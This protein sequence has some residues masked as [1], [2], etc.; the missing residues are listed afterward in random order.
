MSQKFANA[1]R[2]RLVSGINA[3]VTTITVEAPTADLFPIVNTTDWL[4]KNDWFKA[5]LQNSLGQ[6]EIIHVGVRA[7]GSGVF[8]NVLRGQDGTTARE[9]NAGDVVG[10]RL[11]AL[12]HEGLINIKSTDNTFTG[13]NTFEQPIVGNLNGNAETATLAAVATLANA[14]VDEAVSTTKIVDEAVTTPKIDDQAVT[15]PKLGDEAVTQEKLAT[16]VTDR[17]AQ[18]GDLKYTARRTAPPGWLKAN[19]A[20]VSRTTYA[21]L[22]DAICTMLGTTTF[23]L[24]AEGN[25]VLVT[26]SG[27]EIGVDQPLQF[28]TT[29]ALPAGMPATVYVKTIESPGVYT[30]AASAGG[31]A[32][33][34]APG[35][36]Q[37]G[38]HTTRVLP[39]G[40]GDGST[41]FNLPDSRGDFLRA[42][43]D[44][45]G[46]DAGRAVG[47]FQA[48]EF[49]SHSHTLSR[50][51]GNVSGPST[52]FQRAELGNP[53]TESTNAVGGA[54]TR[55]RNLAFLL[56]IKY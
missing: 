21:A 41:T 23:G 37:S 13:S 45:R 42:W 18:P 32:I 15:T 39:F 55:P 8:S 10:L 33:S 4:T 43:D 25:P 31:P 6:F 38:V 47:T 19:G 28:T 46:V 3:S 51:S 1:A 48:D 24:Q 16:E 20:A 49:R 40:L 56:C 9:W 22:F 29:G 44:G 2:S 50:L 26:I 17:Q 11:T 35:T 5:T 52:R 27:S 14:V 7:S 53:N 30:V 36:P 54:E 34:I 12:D